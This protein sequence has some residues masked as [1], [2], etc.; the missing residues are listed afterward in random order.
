MCKCGRRRICIHFSLTCNVELALPFQFARK[1]VVEM[2]QSKKEKRKAQ[3]EK[4]GRRSSNALWRLYE[5]YK[6]KI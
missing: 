3:V 1:V 6:K 5:R 4:V 2:G